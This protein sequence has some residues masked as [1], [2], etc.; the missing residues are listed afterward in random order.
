LTMT[1]LIMGMGM[2]TDASIVIL[3]N[4]FKY[5]ERGAKAPIAAIL[6]SREMMRAIVTSTVTTLC[7]F[8]PLIIYKNDLKEMGQL[9]SDLIFTVV[10]SL[11]VSLL[12]AI[13]LVPSLCGSILRLDTAGKNR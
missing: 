11:T 6:G 8:V 13:T 10:I 7:V 4:V 5:R 2:T 12:V 3:E 1:G 9:F